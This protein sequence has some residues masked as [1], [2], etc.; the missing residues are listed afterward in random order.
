M[1]LCETWEFGAS[2]DLYWQT[3]SPEHYTTYIIIIITHSI[4]HWSEV[5]RR[6]VYNITTYLHIITSLRRLL[7]HLYTIVKTSVAINVSSPSVVFLL[8]KRNMISKME[9][10]SRFMTSLMF[11]PSINSSCLRTFFSSCARFPAWT[12]AWQNTLSLSCFTHWSLISAFS[13]TEA[14]SFPSGINVVIV[15]V[16]VHVSLTAAY[17]ACRVTFCRI[18]TVFWASCW[19]KEYMR[20][21]IK[22]AF[23]RTSHVGCKFPKNAP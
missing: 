16:F 10:T 20:C 2:S 13:N 7:L 17:R 4:Q 1:Q 11:Y 6:N 19:N 5:W 18:E 9:L 8:H 23:V 3:T 21:D 12:T 22:S 14:I 15:N